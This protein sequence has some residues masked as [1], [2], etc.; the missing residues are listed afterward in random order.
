VFGGLKPEIGVIYSGAF[1]GAIC[2]ILGGLAIYTIEE[3]H[4]RDLNFIEY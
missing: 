2:F 3:T 1:V 4:G